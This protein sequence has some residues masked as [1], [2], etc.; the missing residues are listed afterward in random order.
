[1]RDPFI[2]LK[3]VLDDW[4][5]RTRA[6]NSEVNPEELLS[7]A[8]DAANRLLIRSQLQHKI[9][10]LPVHDYYTPLPADFAAVIQAAYR[11]KGIKKKQLRERVN[12]FVHKHFQGC[13]VKM[14]LNCPDC[15]ELECECPQPVIK[16][17]VNRVWESANPQL[18]THY[19]GHFH[20][21][22]NLTARGDQT[23][24]YDDSFVL[25]SYRSNA[26]GN[27]KYHIRE[28]VNIHADC[29]IEYEIDMPNM[30]VNMKRGQVLL[31]YAGYRLDDEGF[32][33]IPDNVYVRDAIFK[34]IE[35]DLAYIDYRVKQDAASERFFDKAELR[36]FNAVD[37][38]KSK[39]KFIESDEW[40]DFLENHW[41]KLLPYVTWRKNFNRASR[42]M[43][44]PPRESYNI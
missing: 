29:N 7:F 22:G 1:M 19:M 11:P 34:G 16:V 32:R 25:M 21:Y 9:A 33:M 17:D 41:R 14:E 18:Y 36:F 6:M 40:F 35:K 42:D 24:V 27:V 15:H 2:S 28:C 8:E 10:L 37:L 30:I 3:S 5:T 26:Y 43:Y 13:E 23:C 12:S 44:N 20:G 39:S 31:A 38:V 4:L